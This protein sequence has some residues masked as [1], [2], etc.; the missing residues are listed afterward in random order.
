MC[1]GDDERVAWAPPASHLAVE[2]N[3]ET[4]MLAQE[5]ARMCSDSD[6]SG[7]ASA[8]TT[9]QRCE[10]V[11]WE[12]LCH[13]SETGQWLRK[14]LLRGSKVL[15]VASG[16]RSKAAAY[17]KL[18]RDFGV[19]LYLADEEGSWGRELEAR[20]VVKKFICSSFQG[21]H[22]EVAA[23][24]VA[25][26]AEL[27]VDLD[28]ATTLAEMA[29]PIAARV[30]RQLA[31]PGHDPEAIDTARDKFLMRSVLRKAG[32]CKLPV[33][34]IRERTEEELAEAIAAVGLPA[35]L[36]PSPGAQP[37]PPFWSPLL[38]RK[39]SGPGQLR[40]A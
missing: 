14:E 8:S 16:T 33:Y 28:G 35:V 7:A 6:G 4:R 27:G 5:V 1:Q 31:L 19:E 2:A 24:I 38:A 18:Y 9:A 17:E 11:P 40:Q 37:L 13:R 3:E 39:L 25:D 10:R 34:Q 26:V 15:F 12:L 21:S 36:K 32:V 29:L 23:Q 20:G 30:A 22:D